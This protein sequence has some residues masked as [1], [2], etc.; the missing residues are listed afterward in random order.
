MKSKKVS[1]KNSGMISPVKSLAAM[2]FLSSAATTASADILIGE[3]ASTKLS[4]YGLLDAGILY[5]DKVSTDGDEKVGLESSGLTPTILGFKGSRSLDNG[6]NAFFNLEAHFD[7]DTGMF[8]GTGDASTDS[9]DGSGTVLFRRQANL[10]VS[11]DWGTVIIGRQYGP[12]LL[13]HLGTEPRVFKE[14]FSNVYAWAYSQYFSSINASTTTDGRNANNDVGIFFKNAV[15]YRNSINGLDFGVMYSFGGQEGSQKEGDVI[16]IGAAY[17]TGSVTLSGSYQNMRDQQTA[18]DIITSWGVG[19]AYNAGDLNFKTNYLATENNDAN[20]VQVLDL[21]SVSAGVDWQWSE[22][23]S[24]TVA[25]YINKDKAPSK[26]VETKSLVLSNEYTIGEST[27]VYAQLAHVDAD[28]MGV[29]SRYA[30]SIVASP[31]PAGET[32]TLINVGFNFAF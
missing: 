13:A 8:H 20:G 12:G 25:Y 4:M 23:N 21:E 16:A 5:Q 18:E 14:Q 31:A 28:E 1:R 24:A 29:I 11:G 3:T 32:T 17:N 30:T 10:G 6:M 22:K 9:D 19:A 26:S 7:L 15:Q 27:I 2:I